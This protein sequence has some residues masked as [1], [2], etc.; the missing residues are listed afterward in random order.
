MEQAVIESVEIVE[1]EQVIEL[2]LSLLDK[3]GG[4]TVATTL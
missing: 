3:I 2:P 1:D 4:G